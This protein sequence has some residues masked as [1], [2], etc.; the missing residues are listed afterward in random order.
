MITRATEVV[1]EIREVMMVITRVSACIR[2][3][4]EA[5]TVAIEVILYKV[6]EMLLKKL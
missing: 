6:P 5:S 2:I 4:I 1:T 3:S